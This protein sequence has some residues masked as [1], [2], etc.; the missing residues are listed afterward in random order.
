MNLEA[1]ELIKYL[2]S[3][4]LEVHTSTKA[5]GNQ[6]FYMKNRI[7]ISKNIAPERLMPTLVHEFAHYIHSKIEPFMEK[8]GGSIEVIF[9]DNDKNFYEK[10][11]FDVTRFVDKNSKCEKLELH[12]SMVK[13]R[14]RAYENIIKEYYPKFMR[15]KRF[16]EF[17]KYIKGSNARYLLKYDRVKIVNRGFNKKIEFYSIDNLGKDFCDMPPAFAAYI[18]LKS[19]QKKQTRISSKINRLNKYYSKPSELFARFVEGLYINNEKVKT[20]APNT[21]KR[22]YDLLESGYYLELKHIF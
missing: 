12:K 14:I 11:L 18:R 3:I 5:R 8:S 13:E 9:D 19:C 10:E 6:G 4:G 20:L 7:D 17:D 22:F 15:S 2:R 16:K 1:K 21:C